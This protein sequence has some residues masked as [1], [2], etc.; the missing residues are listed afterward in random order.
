MRRHQKL[1]KEVQTRLADGERKAH[2][3]NTLKEKYPAAA[4]ERSLAQWPCPEA[5][6][7]NRFLNVPLLIIAAVF[8]LTKTLRL[9]GIFQSLE[10]SQ[11]LAG[12]LAI[13]IH[14]YILYGVL[15][16]NLIGYMLVL[17]MSVT[18]LLGTRSA[19]AANALPLALVWIQKSR[20]FP[21][22][23]WL[24]RHKKDSS[25]NIIF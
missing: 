1:A 3:Y 25:G 9:I 11:Q 4:V 23:S 6:A 24:L 14:L 17:L 22:T 21:N 13:L 15:N 20:L 16:F 2:I 8:T 18:T 5:R 7:K 12:V 10:L 19:G